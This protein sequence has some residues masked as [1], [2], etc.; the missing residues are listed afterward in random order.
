VGGMTIKH[1]ARGFPRATLKSAVITA[2]L[3]CS[4]AAQ[5]EAVD[6]LRAFARD[7]SSAKAT[8]TQTV[9]APDGAKKKPSTGTFEFARPNRFRFDYQ[10][11]YPQL[12]V[13]DGNQV[14]LHDPDLQQVTVRAMD[15]AMGATPA[16]LLAGQSLDKDFV[17]KAEPDAD[18]LSWLMATPKVKEGAAFE[19]M[20]VGFRGNTLAAVEILDTFG[21]RTLMQFAGM[22]TSPAFAAE[23]FK[24]VPP[25]GTDVLKQ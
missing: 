13:G 16:A 1:A 23:H 18:G 6:A 24:F 10:K 4:A 21:Q 20:R 2:T 15:K 22:N 9:T 3:L 11:P 17:L 14:W 25:A 12:I 19:S 7:V 8:F 5:A